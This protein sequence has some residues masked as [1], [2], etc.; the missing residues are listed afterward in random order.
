M[1]GKLLAACCELERERLNG[2]SLRA[3]DSPLVS[4]IKTQVV[5]C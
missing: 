3:A 5:S 1:G 4:V 2:G